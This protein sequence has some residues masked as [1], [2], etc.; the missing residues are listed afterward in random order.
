MASARFGSAIG[1]GLSFVFGRHQGVK[2]RAHRS[3]SESLTFCPPADHCPRID[4][5][6][7]VA[8][9]LK[10]SLQSVCIKSP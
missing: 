4:I 5:D 10:Q 2:I 6:Y 1:G 9:L 3:E 8:S 7:L